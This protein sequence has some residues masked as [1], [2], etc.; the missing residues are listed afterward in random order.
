MHEVPELNG[1]GVCRKQPSDCDSKN[2]PTRHGRAFML[3]A[4]QF[5]MFSTAII[6]PTCTKTVGPHG[7]TPALPRS[8]RGVE[9]PKR[10]EL[11]IGNVLATLGLVAEYRSNN[12]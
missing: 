12:S 3:A 8:C 2:G 9:S 1:D 11:R 4:D 10:L 7:L 6:E 5:G